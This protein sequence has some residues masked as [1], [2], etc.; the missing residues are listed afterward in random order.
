MSLY[1][2]GETWWIYLTH[3][4]Q[5]IRQ[6]AKTDDKEVAQRQH[7]E[8]KAR[9]WQRRH[10]SG[11]T[12]REAV[13]AWLK[14]A[15]RDDADKYRLGSLEIPDDPLSDLT[16]GTFLTALAGK[17][18]ATHNRY[19]NLITA[20]LNL[21]KARG[22]LD[23]VPVIER[24]RIPPATFRWLT[25]AEWKR[26]EK[27]LPEHLLPLAR[28]AV[29]TGLRQFNVTHL[30]WEYVDLRRRTV[31]IPPEEMKAGKVISIPLSNDAVGVLRSQ[32]GKDKTW[33]FPYE[34]H[35]LAQIKG[36]WGKA[37]KR[38]GIDC[39][40]HDLRHTW[41]SWQVQAGVPLQVVQELGGWA[42]YQMMLKYAHL[43]HEHLR[44]WVNVGHKPRHKA[45]KK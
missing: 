1:K 3:H 6:S 19:V 43:S 4:G 41:A 32:L 38:A 9:L 25:R 30:R 31:T 36:A 22:W 7:D 18:P 37:C 8:L 5:R 42:S 29:Y 17:K 15:P 23:V 33:V 27:A 45:A 13:A 44:K 14:V 16:A 10:V 2:R 12:W 39:R 20:I 24:R 11:A 21:A 26:L 28:F 40:W 35:P 34:G